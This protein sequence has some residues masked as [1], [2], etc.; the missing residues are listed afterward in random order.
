MIQAL[1]QVNIVYRHLNSLA[2][3]LSRAHT[4]HSAASLARQMVRQ[5]GMTWIGPCMHPLMIVL[6]F[7]SRSDPGVVHGSGP[8]QTGKSKCSRNKQE[9]TVGSEGVPHIL[10]QIHVAPTPTAPLSN[11][12]MHRAPVCPRTSSPHNNT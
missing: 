5:A 9:E 1:Y 2:D 8:S 12:Y 7:R 10:S 4:L 11:V 6:P 3:A